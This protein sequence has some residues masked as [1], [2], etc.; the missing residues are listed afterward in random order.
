MKRKCIIIGF[1]VL[2]F[3]TIILGIVLLSNNDKGKKDTKKDEF[4]KKIVSVLTIDVNPSIEINLNKDNVVVSVKALNDDSKKIVGDYNYEKE[5]IEDVLS[6]LVTNLKENNYLNDDNNVILIN[7]STEDKKL[8][9]MVEEVTN[10]VLTEKEIKSEI[11]IQSVEETDELKK[12]ADENN[13]TVSKAYY[14]NEQIKDEEGLTFE[15]VK[16]VSISEIKE[17]VNEIKEEQAKKNET[18]I[19]ENNVD[20]NNYSD[21][22]GSIEKCHYVK[23]NISIDQAVNIAVSHAGGVYNPAGYCDVR[24][25]DAY[26]SLSPEGVCSIMVS[27]DIGM[28]HCTYYIN[29]ETG[30]I[31][32][33][34]V[35]NS[36]P[37]SINESQCIIMRDIGVSAREQISIKTETD[38]GSEMVST[39]ED[40]YGKLYEYHI[41]KQSG[42]IISKTPI[43]G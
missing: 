43:E 17:K 3:L 8:S 38:T 33:S 27:F 1:V 4:D 26:G 5:T 19:E 34:P 37:L 30:D 21:N 28:K 20:Q 6:K 18:K 35:C 29:V 9:S 31:V 10:K 25:V 39:V 40:N 2:L 41:S 22:K 11:V 12:I 42:V 14:I 36:I 32:A 15:D 16:D 23:E 13:I 7:V 24:S